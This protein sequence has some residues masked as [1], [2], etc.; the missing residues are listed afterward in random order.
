MSA[1]LYVV[2]EWVPDLPQYPR[3]SFATE[4]HAEE[5]GSNVQRVQGC[6]SLESAAHVVSELN[7]RRCQLPASARLV[8]DENCG[9]C[10][11]SSGAS[12]FTVGHGD[13]QV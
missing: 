2:V 4:K 8:A 6:N 5:L 12:R 9:K 7:A 11:G 13:G 1:T 10:V 3:Y